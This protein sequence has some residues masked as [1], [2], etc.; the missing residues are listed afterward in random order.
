MS[1]VGQVPRLLK[2]EVWKNILSGSC[3]KNF[4]KDDFTDEGFIKVSEAAEE[5]IKEK[6]L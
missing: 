2:W 3:V 5:D 1:D 4:S 6:T